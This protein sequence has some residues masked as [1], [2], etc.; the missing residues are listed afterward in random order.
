MLYARLLLRQFTPK[1][2][3][4]PEVYLPAI[5]TVMTHYPLDVLEQVVDPFSGLPGAQDQMPT[6]HQVKMA[7]EKVYAPRRARYGWE[8]QAKKQAAER[9]AD[10]LARASP[11]Q[12]LTEIEDDMAARGIFMSGWRERHKRA[13]TSEERAAIREQLGPEK[14]DA[15]PNKGEKHG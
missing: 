12:S 15:T 10:E 1:F 9:A 7:C 4:D 11:R 8:Q 3:V 2:G 13:A 6:P 14:F 5:V